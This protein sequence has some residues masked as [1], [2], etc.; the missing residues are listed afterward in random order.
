MRQGGGEGLRDERSAEGKGEE[1]IASFASDFIHRV[2]LTHMQSMGRESFL[3]VVLY[4]EVC[5]YLYAHVHIIILYCNTE[6]WA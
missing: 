3:P 5:M 2:R 1:F 6:L 4:G